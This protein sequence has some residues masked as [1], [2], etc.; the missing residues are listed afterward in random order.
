MLSYDTR[1]IH[2]AP[3]AF[4]WCAISY[5]TPNLP[6]MPTSINVAESKCTSVTNEVA[7]H[8]DLQDQSND[9]HSVNSSV[10]WLVYQNEVQHCHIAATCT[11][12]YMSKVSN[13]KPSS[14]LHIYTSSVMLWNMNSYGE[15]QNISCSWSQHIKENALTQEK[16]Y[17]E[18]RKWNFIN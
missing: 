18:W 12:L 1:T 4:I 15:V 10:V 16:L 7:T 3:Q 9:L 14:C 11:H 17:K 2:N 5:D 13:L 8:L 6:C